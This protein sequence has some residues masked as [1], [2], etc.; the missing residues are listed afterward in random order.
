MSIHAQLMNQL[1]FDA[2]F[3]AFLATELQAI[4]TELYRVQY[5]DLKARLWLPLKTDVPAGAEEFGYDVLDG[6]GRAD[7]I[8]H[9]SDEL[10][11]AA[12]RKDRRLGR[13]V[14]V[15]NFF[16]YSKQELR[17]A[18]MANMPL[19]RE[20][21]LFAMRAHEERFND[22]VLNGLPALG[23]IGFFKHPDVPTSTAV[24]DWDNPATTGAQI[25]ADLR[26]LYNGV[27]QQSNGV[28]TPTQIIL[29]LSSY[30]AAS[31]RPVAADFNIGTSALQM[32]QQT[33]GGQGGPVQVD[34]DVNL[35]TAGPGGVKRAVA[36]LKRPDI[37]QAV[38]PLAPEISEPQLHNLVYKRTV[39][40]RV[41]GAIVRQSLGMR[42]LDGL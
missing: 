11:N 25:L 10:P 22:L 17:A 29:P 12:V 16:A 39:E 26:T 21:A 15:G 33:A 18:A 9:N 38:Q 30:L 24:A 37:A 23:M 3:S 32:F 14:T 8:T 35:E 19:D 36:Y 27:I 6:V 7:V 42:Y 2:Q 13:V 41:G 31:S 4:E 28:Y 34:W 20:V 5:Q 1:R 40:S